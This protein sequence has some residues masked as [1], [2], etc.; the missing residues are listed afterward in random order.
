[1]LFRPVYHANMLDYIRKLLKAVCYYCSHLL[2]E[3]GDE[4]QKDE[5]KAN[6]LAELKAYAEISN[7]KARFTRV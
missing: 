1:M 2:A 5:K 7:A 3:D 4:N 6:H